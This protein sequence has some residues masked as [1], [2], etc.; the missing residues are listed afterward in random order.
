MPERL[1]AALAGALLAPGSVA[2][3]QTWPSQTVKMV[4]PYPA[5]GATDFDR[6]L[7]RGKTAGADRL[8]VHRRESRRRRRQYRCRFGRQGCA[9][10]PYDHLFNINGMA[11]APAIY[12]K[13]AYDPDNDFIRVSQVGATATVLVVNPQVPAKTFQELVTLAKAKPGVLN[14]GSTGVGNS[15][16]LTMELLKRLTE[17][18]IQMV[19][20]TGDAPLF[21]SLFRNDIQMAMVPVSITKEHITGGAVRAVGVTTLKRL[22]SLPDVPT[23]DEQGLKGF[24][25]RGWMGLFV[26]KGTPAPIVDRLYRE[27]KKALDAADLRQRLVGLEIEPMGTTP[28]EFDKVF[29]QDLE[30]FARIIKDANIPQQ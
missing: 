6:A 20:F 10:R 13:L 1:L 28:A 14:Y 18:Q 17:T 11:I 24:E 22:A 30:R 16:H 26:P 4:V 25:M 12:K 9:R 2:T 8:G 19:P 29:R 5:G 3:A 21:L 7:A 15:L 23:L 27:T